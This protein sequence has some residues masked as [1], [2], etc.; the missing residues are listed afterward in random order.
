M[1]IFF[2]NRELN[3]M[4]QRVLVL[5]QGQEQVVIERLQA[6]LSNPQA[7]FEAQLYQGADG[8]LLILKED[9]EGIEER[10]FLRAN[11]QGQN[12]QYSERALSTAG[13]QLCAE[14]QSE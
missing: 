7:S 11:A 8:L 1:R 13:Y 12:W 14:A 4:S 10:H 6:M 9:K 3:W 2:E 5:E